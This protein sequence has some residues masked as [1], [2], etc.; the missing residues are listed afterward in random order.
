MFPVPR[1]GKT[2][3]NPVESMNSALKKFI[4]QDITSM[5]VS[6]NNYSMRIFKE[7]RQKRF[8]SSI[9]DQCIKKLTKNGTQSLTL[10]NLA[11]SSSS[12]IYLVDLNYIVN[13]ETKSCAA[14]KAMMLVYLASIY[15]QKQSY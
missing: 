7:R 14:E 10:T 11:S 3:S 13:L 8:Q 1:F 9:V 15:A 6:I 2:T 12:S 5:I 4:G